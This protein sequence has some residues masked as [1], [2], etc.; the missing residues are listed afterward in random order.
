MFIALQYSEEEYLNPRR[1]CNA[2]KDLSGNPI[3]I[4][5]QM[6]VDEFTN[7]LFDRLENQLKGCHNFINNHFG[8]VMAN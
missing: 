8:G 1:F 3:N 6:D 2:F 7:I 4:F 5:E